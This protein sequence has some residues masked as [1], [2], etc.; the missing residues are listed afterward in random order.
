MAT[1]RVAQIVVAIVAEGHI[2]HPTFTEMS[3]T[4]DIVT[5]S[6]AILDAEHKGAL[7]FTLD[8]V[9]VIRSVGDS[10]TA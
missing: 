3:Y 1:G 8:T 6:V 10:Y 7:A 5:N 9:K 2:Y 4:G